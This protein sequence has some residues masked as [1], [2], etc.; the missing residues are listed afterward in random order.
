MITDAVLTVLLALMS[1]VVGFLPDG[2]PLGLSSASGLWIGY[3][4]L[5]TFLPLTE[6]LAMFG[7]YLGVQVAL[8]AYGVLRAVRNWLPFV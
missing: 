2:D 1:F 7:A 8:Y 3:A 6:L 5:N 4:Q